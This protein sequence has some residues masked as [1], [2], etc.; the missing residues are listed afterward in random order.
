MASPESLHLGNLKK[1]KSAKDIPPG[2]PCDADL[3]SDADA[4]LAFRE[5]AAVP[6]RVPKG[7]GMSQL[8][9]D[10]LPQICEKTI[11]YTQVEES[12]NSLHRRLENSVLILVPKEAGTPAA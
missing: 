12:A 6:D 3:Y 2:V 11:V 4:I 10:T 5:C 1:N 8:F 7:E 9:G